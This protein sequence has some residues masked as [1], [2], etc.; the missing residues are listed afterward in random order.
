MFS[1]PPIDKSAFPPIASLH[2]LLTTFEEATRARGKNTDIYKDP[3]VSNFADKELIRALE[4]KC[5]EDANFIVPEGYR[6]VTEKTA[7]FK[8]EVPKCAKDL[9]GPS[10]V[11]A[12]ELLDM[13]LE[14]AVGTH[15]LEPLIT[16]EQEVKVKPA[17][18]N[19]PKIP[20]G[21]SYMD[22][23]VRK[24]VEEPKKNA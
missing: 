4:V 12:T 5:R 16:F 22:K 17:I 10:K 18:A 9:L 19:K 8:Y 20:A 24:E 15:F 7:V 23:I 3:D 14:K 13:I 11:I 1:R 6:K 21:H 2:Q